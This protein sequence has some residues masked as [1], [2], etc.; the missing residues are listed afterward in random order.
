MVNE[1]LEAQPPQEGLPPHGHNTPAPPPVDLTE[2]VDIGASL[3]SEMDDLKDKEKKPLWYIIP[4]RGLVFV[5]FRPPALAI[6]SPTAW[7]Q[8]LCRTVA[9]TRV[10]KSR[11][12]IKIQPVE[13]TSFAGIDEIKAITKP[14]CARE[15]PVA[16]TGT[17]ERK[18]EDTKG[19]TSASACEKPSFAV[20]YVS[21][22]GPKLD[23]LTVIDAVVDH[24]SMSSYKVSLDHPDKTILITLF[25][26]LSLVA[27]VE[28]WN[29]IRRGN[30][31]I[32]A[33]I[34][35][36]E[37]ARKRKERIMAAKKADDD[38]DKE[39]ETREKDQEG[40]ATTSV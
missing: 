39:E 38:E 2:V 18:G 28:K 10:L 23:R 31:R 7:V 5:Q 14:I 33:G 22:L 21:K 20:D 27:V 12:I 37:E 1:F 29:D 9:H 15:F 25:K 13:N 6:S 17:R 4:H 16:E 24:I 35:D 34:D 11:H 30:M 36:Q 8:S 3:Q 26:G 19:E 40:A 32:L